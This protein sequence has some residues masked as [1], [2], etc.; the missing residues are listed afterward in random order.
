MQV[1]EKNVL[2][3]AEDV[4]QEKT[5]Q[6]LIK[7]VEE[8]SP[9]KLKNVKTREPATGAEGKKKLFLNEHHKRMQSAT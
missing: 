2:P 3:T 8:F 4:A 5:H 1:S 7:S 6:G 9:E